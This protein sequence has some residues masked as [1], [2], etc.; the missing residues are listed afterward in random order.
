MKKSI[1]I[2]NVEIPIIIR[3]YKNSKS[4][5]IYFK[6][7]VLNISKPIYVSQREV[8]NIIEK[9][10][11]EIY[12]NYINYIEKEKENVNIKYWN[13]RKKIFFKGIE[14]QVKK[15]YG[16]D[17]KKVVICINEKEC[18]IEIN[19]PLIYNQIEY[20][21]KIKQEID[22]TIKK[23]FKEQT[24]QLLE[25]KL[26]FWSKITGISYNKVNINDTISKYGS[27]KPITKE[28]YFSSRLIMLPEDKVDGIIVHELCHIIYANHSMKFYELVKKYIPNYLEI[29]KWLKIHPEQISL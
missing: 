11:E 28:L 13:D 25:N 4:I 17:Y 19:I 14:Y 8:K 1:I 5:K 21:E 26:S 20:N 27:C 7:N 23:V 6:K 10:K 18:I 2:N 29:D 3:N 22:K 15:I 24:K 12:I 16:K 9:N